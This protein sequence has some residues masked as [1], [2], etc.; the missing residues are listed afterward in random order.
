M[1]VGLWE[2]GIS[3]LLDS[4]SPVS[5]FSAGV[6]IAMSSPPE[7]GVGCH[8]DGSVEIAG[9]DADQLRGINE[10]AERLLDVVWGRGFDVVLELD[11]PGVV[12]AEIEV[13]RQIARELIVRGA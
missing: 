7:S 1:K 12:A 10:L 3:V 8:M 9:L 5:L 2:C 6:P 11:I 4:F 13:I